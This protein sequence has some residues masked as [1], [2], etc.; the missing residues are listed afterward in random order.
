MSIGWRANYMSAQGR[1]RTD[2]EL[3]LIEKAYCSLSQ[4]YTE[5]SNHLRSLFRHVLPLLCRRPQRFPCR[6]GRFAL[7]R[8]RT[9]MVWIK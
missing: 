4:E 2:I 5:R 6:V 7:S 9:D 1:R 3:I 8:S